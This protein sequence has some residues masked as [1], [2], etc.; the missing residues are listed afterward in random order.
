MPTTAPR[1]HRTSGKP[2]PRPAH[3]HP[4]PNDTGRIRA[5]P[6]A[7]CR[8]YRFLL[9]HAAQK[10][11]VPRVSVSRP[12]YRYRPAT[13]TAT[14][15]ARGLRSAHL[16]AAAIPRVGR[17][18]VGCAREVRTLRS[19]GEPH[20]DIYSI[21]YVPAGQLARERACRG[22]PRRRNRR[23][24][25]GERLRPRVLSRVSRRT[26]ETDDDPDQQSRSFGRWLR[27]PSRP[28][29]C[30]RRRAPRADGPRRRRRR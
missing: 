15:L 23:T 29:G 8:D 13:P 11:V 20:E 12:L 22:R 19:S 2:A 3:H 16:P 9:P 28:H 4:T 24:G 25:D 10:T 14:H 18:Q 7:P 5:A 27:G 6:G 26:M 17:K 1:P 30:S 21:G